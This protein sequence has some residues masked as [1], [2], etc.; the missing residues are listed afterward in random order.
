MCFVALGCDAGV[1]MVAPADAGASC[2]DGRR[3]TTGD[4][5]DGDG[6]CVG[7]PVLCP[8][9]GAC[10]VG[11]CV[12]ADGG[13][14]AVPDPGAVCS[15]DNVC[16]DNDTCAA[17]GGCEGTPITCPPASE[18]EVANGCDSV[19][20]CAYTPRTNQPCDGGTCNALGQCQAN[21]GQT[22]PYVPSNFTEAQLAGV[23]S[24]NW[25]VTCPTTVNT[26]TD[27]GGFSVTSHCN[28]AVPAGLVITQVDAGLPALVLVAN[29]FTLAP[30]GTLRAEGARP[31]ILAIRGNATVGGIIDVEGDNLA[32]S[33]AGAGLECSGG[34]GAAGV[35]GARSSGGGGGAFGTNAS[36]GGAAGSLTVSGTIA[37][38]GAGGLGAP[39]PNQGAGDGGGGGGGSV[40]RIRF[41]STMGCTIQSTT[42]SPRHTGSG[43]GCP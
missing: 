38:G 31:L 19:T 20:G 11:L 35:T 42:I 25:T 27:D 7:W 8:S 28:E 5:C 36:A 32:R 1:C 9:P 24:A 21:A 39:I 37:A 40:G 33:A 14:A 4:F 3:C 13:C 10:F 34:Q 41:N 16:T 12:E 17:D 29:D 23:P 6:G 30:S 22:F 2:D 43:P 15:D 18:C 26:Q